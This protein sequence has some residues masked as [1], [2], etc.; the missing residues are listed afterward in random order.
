MNDGRLKCDGC[1]VIRKAGVVVFICP[2]TEC[3]AQRF[4]SGL[5]GKKKD[6]DLPIINTCFT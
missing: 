5:L 1:C 2:N 3:T 4:Y 6:L